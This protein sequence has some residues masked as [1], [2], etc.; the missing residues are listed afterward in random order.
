MAD[1][2]LQALLSTKAA[3]DLGLVSQEDYDAVKSAFLRAQQLRA[4]VDTGLMREEDYEATKADY[5]SSLTLGSQDSSRSQSRQSNGS[6]GA[7]APQAQQ[8]AVAPP[9]PPSKQ[10]PPAAPSAPPP[11]A[12]PPVQ[13]PLAAPRPPPLPATSAAPPAAAPLQ[14]VA[15]PR[16]GGAAATVP[17][18][19]PRLGGA[20]TISSGVSMSGISVSADAVN[21]YYLVRA[22]S[23][24]KWALWKIDEAGTTVVIDAVGEPDSTYQDFLNALPESDC[25]Y[26]MFDYKLHTPDGQVLDKLVFLNWAP[27]TARIKAKMMYASTKD[28]FKGH[29][30]GLSTEFQAS[31][32]DEIA[33]QDIADAVAA[34]KR[35]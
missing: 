28:F 12:P 27:D 16:S 19:I 7:V 18:N 32:L 26:G 11:P 8:V 15:T 20:K 9:Q 1:P 34:L 25:R 29:L 3:L 23:T 30:D 13:A 35:K 22:K 10:P 33:E 5:L 14:P 2:T 17:S 4:A 24:Y 21:L 31:D 6:Q